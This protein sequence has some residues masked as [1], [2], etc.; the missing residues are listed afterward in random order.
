M[1][2]LSIK[3]PSN[4]TSPGA[5]EEWIGERQKMPA[6]ISMLHLQEKSFV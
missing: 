5:L 6:L 3:M 1:Q 4:I 2:L